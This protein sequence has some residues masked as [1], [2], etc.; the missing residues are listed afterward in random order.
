M[1]LSRISDEYDMSFVDTDRVYNLLQIALLK[2]GIKMQSC[3]A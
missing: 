1:M 3:I 2:A